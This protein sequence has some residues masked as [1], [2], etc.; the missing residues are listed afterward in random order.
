MEAGIDCSLLPALTVSE[1]NPG[2]VHELWR[3]LE[4]LPYTA[5]YRCYG[6]LASKMDENLSPELAMAKALTTDATKRML[7]RLSKDNT[8]QYGPPPRQDLAL[9]PGHRLR[10]HP[11]PGAGLRQHDRAHRRHA[12]VRL[13]HEL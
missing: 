12:Q 13:A 5:R 11:Q 4:L 2:L 8:K 10:D 6:V 9:Q 1:A 7:R 3:L